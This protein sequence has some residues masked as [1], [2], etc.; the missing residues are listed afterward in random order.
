M[1]S[2][3]ELLWLGRDFNKAA[4]HHRVGWLDYREWE[5]GW[6]SGRRLRCV[7][8]PVGVSEFPILNDKRDVFFSD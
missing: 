7:V 1:N 4:G 3:I 6:K 5:W 2:M 8:V